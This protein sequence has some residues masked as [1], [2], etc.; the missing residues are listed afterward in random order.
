MMH[1]EL[2]GSVRESMNHSLTDFKGSYRK[3]ADHS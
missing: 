2:S 3:I 1:V